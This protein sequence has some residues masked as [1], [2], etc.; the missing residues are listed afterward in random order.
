MDLAPQAENL[1]RIFTPPSP[2]IIVVFEEQGEGGGEV[3]GTPPPTLTRHS[4]R[5]QTFGTLWQ[6]I[7]QQPLWQPSALKVQ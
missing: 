7:C 4:E 5:V 3:P 1:K 6:R 2:L